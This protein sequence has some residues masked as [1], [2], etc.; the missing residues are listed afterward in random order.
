[1]QILQQ[2][3]NTALSLNTQAAQGHTK[4][5]GVSELTTGH[6]IALQREESSST[7]QKTNASF[8]NQETLTSQPSNPTHNEEPPQ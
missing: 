6:S 3:R 1:M 2:P 8:P 7:H 4:P 5:A